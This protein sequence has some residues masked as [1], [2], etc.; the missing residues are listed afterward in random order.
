[1]NLKSVSVASRNMNSRNMLIGLIA[2]S[3]NSEIVIAICINIAMG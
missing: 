2:K 1:M 3:R